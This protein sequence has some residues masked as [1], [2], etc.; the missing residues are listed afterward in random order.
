M[1]TAEAV[2][3]TL[4]DH[5]EDV[6][7]QIRENCNLTNISYDTWIA[8]LS[9]LSY[10]DGVVS[11]LIP[12]DNFL[13]QSYLE[14]HY[15]D[16]FRV[17]LSEQAGIN[18]DVAFVLPKETPS[19]AEKDAQGDAFSAEETDTPLPSLS[20]FSGL[21]EKYRFDN[22]VV[23]GNNNFA[24]SAAV[25]V[26]ETPGVTYNPLFL[27]GGPGLGKTHLMHSIGHFIGM[28]VPGSKILYVTSEHF[29]NEVI[30]AI[31]SG[32]KDSKIM[33]RFREKYRTVDVLLL[34]D[35]QFIIGKESTQ[36][37]FF[38]TFNALKEAGKQ[39]VLSSDK[40]PKQMETLEERF[41]SRFESGL[42]ADIQA[43][44][45][46]TKMAIMKKLGEQYPVEIDDGAYAYIAN[47][48]KSNIRQLEGAF[49]KI[50]AH[51][52]INAVPR[53]TE[54]IAADA[55]KD[56]LYPDADR[57]ITYQR[58]IDT[59]CEHFSVSQEELL[60]QKRSAEI[61]LPR[62]LAMFLCRK[63]VPN[64]SY[65]EIGSSL[66]GKDHTTVMNGE[67]RV[68][69]L[70]KTDAEVQRTMDVLLKKLNPSL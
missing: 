22:F 1:P 4:S 48:I 38:H 27:Y 26:A 47:N 2:S 8:P 15:I 65:K 23:G 28:N 51:S 46:E 36:E 39:I 66:G 42:I 35:V 52:R 34:D 68:A 50:I 63:H 45:Y 64:N 55:L 43:P 53:I 69:E 16:F 54:E 5:F 57:I 10:R 32:Q 44:D 7:E 24:Y 18:V 29:T 61:V 11:I 21:N 6:K 30:E 40:P 19:A 3:Q 49:N 37:E 70:L 56:F 60:S 58:V 14:K 12:T 17:F 20:D 31:R 41:R 67:K 59:V 9:F 13:Q 62:Q 33:S 25:A